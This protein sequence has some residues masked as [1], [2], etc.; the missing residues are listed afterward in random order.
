MAA[1]MPF[2]KIKYDGKQ[3][4][5]HWTETKAGTDI[6]HVMRC[7]QQP[8]PAFKEVF[9]GIA[10]PLV[11]NFLDL[12]AHWNIAVTGLSINIEDNDERLG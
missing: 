12:P 9:S 11:M 3:V 6:E 10:R 2:T 5:L 8:T 4:E 1:L 7:R